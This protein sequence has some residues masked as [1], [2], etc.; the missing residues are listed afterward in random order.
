MS[1]EEKPEETPWEQTPA[2]LRVF[3]VVALLAFLIL[4]GLVIWAAA[5]H[6]LSF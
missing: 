2:S 5:I 6:L 4:V 1:P 3:F